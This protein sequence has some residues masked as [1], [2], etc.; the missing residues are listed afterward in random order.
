MSWKDRI[1]DNICSVRALAD[2]LELDATHRSRLEMSPSFRLNLPLRLAEKIPKNCLDHPLARQFVPLKEESARE[3][4]WLDDPVHDTAFQKSERLLQKYQGRVLVVSTGACAMHCRYCFRQNYSYPAAG[5]FPSQEVDLISRD[6]SIHEV[7]L[8]GGDPLSLPDHVLARWVSALD[9][10]PHVKRLRLHTRFPIGI[11][12]R[13]TEDLLALL[14]HTRLQVWMVVHCNHALELDEEVCRALKRVLRSGIPVLNQAV[15]LRGVN[16]DLQAQID[17]CSRLVDHGIQ[18]YYLHQLDRVQGAQHF[19]VPVQQG[20]EL[21]HALRSRVSG[22]AVPQY[23]AEIPGHPSKT[24]VLAAEHDA[25][26]SGA[27]KA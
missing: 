1:R 20:L 12:E 14:S 19:E 15:L 4:G 10:I 17:L 9:S 21:I 11:P 8:S 22:Y 16:D 23:V 5:S 7:I 18:P 26:N 3:K 24:P 27:P 6:P 25:V 13:I 2:Y